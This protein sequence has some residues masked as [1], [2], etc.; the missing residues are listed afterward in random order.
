MVEATAKVEH[1]EHVSACFSMVDRWGS[2]F[3]HL[4]NLPEA[5]YDPHERGSLESLGE[6]WQ[7]SLSERT[8]G[9]ELQ[10]HCSSREKDQLKVE[11]Q[12]MEDH[13]RFGWRGRI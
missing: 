12:I 6:P 11:P 1:V 4:P 9:E 7:T 5:A 2:T 10:S 3:L 13:G 8:G